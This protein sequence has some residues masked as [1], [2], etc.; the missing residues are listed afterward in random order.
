MNR[1]VPERLEKMVAD[2][3]L[4]RKSGQGFYRWEGNKPQKP[5]A[6]QSDVPADIEDQY[7][8]LQN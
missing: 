4:G 3:H 7:N 1:P 2:G 8:P 5:T 6:A